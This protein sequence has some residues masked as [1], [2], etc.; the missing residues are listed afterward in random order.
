MAEAVNPLMQEFLFEANENL[1]SLNELLPHLEKN[2]ADKELLNKIYRCVHTVK[3]GA[4]F[5]KLIRLDELTH[6]LENLLDQV[7]DGKKSVDSNIIDVLLAG[8]DFM[9]KIIKAVESGAGEAK[10]DLGDILSKLAFVLN[11][12]SAPDVN[13]AP[14]KP[15]E[16]VHAQAKDKPPE[17]SKQEAAPFEPIQVSPL[18]MKSEPVASSVTAPQAK[19]PSSVSDSK[20]ANTS[21]STNDEKNIGD[22]VVRV[23]VNLLDKIM[24][25]VGELVLTRN[26][27]LQFANGL[28]SPDLYKLSNQLNSITTE[29]QGDIMRTR[30]QPIGSILS[31]FD[32]IVRDL[33]REMGKKVHLKV[34]GRDTELDKTLLEAIKDPL[35]HMVR[36]AVDHAIETCEQRVEAGKS[37]EG[38]LAIKAY[39]EGGQVTIEIKDDGRGIRKDKVLAKAIEKGIITKD[40]ASQMS[41]KE[42]FN[43]IFMPG[44]STAAQVTNISGRG[45][46]MDVV[47]TNIE[48]IGGQ[49]DLTSEEGL[50]TTFKLRI[51]LTLA[52]IPALVVHDKGEV[53][54]L[55]QIN[56]VELVRLEGDKLA[57]IEKINGAEFFRLRG[58]LIPLVRLSR[59][60]NL[61]SESH[62][63]G[64]AVEAEN[65]VVLNAEGRVYGL[66]VD[67]ILDTQEIVVKPL[68][69]QLKNLGYYAGATI[70][71]DGRVALILDVMGLAAKCELQSGDSAESEDTGSGAYASRDAQEVLLFKLNAKGTFCVP[72]VVVNRLEKI[73]SSRIEFIGEQ[74]TVRYREQP[75]PLIDLGQALGFA[76]IQDL[77]SREV[78]PVFVAVFGGKY[79][80]FIV[81]D[82]LDISKSDFDIKTNALEGEG[83]LGALF[84]NDRT[85]T[86]VDIY[87]VAEKLQ[88]N[89]NTKAVDLRNREHS[90]TILLAEDTA[91]FRKI[92][93]MTF[94]ALGYK[95]L[96]G[97]NGKE[98]LDLWKQHYSEIDLI[99]SDVE[100]PQMNG[101]EFA[102]EIRKHPQGARIPMIALT[103]KFSKE[104]IEAGKA[105]GFNMYLEKFK[106]QEIVEAVLTATKAG[107]AA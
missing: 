39:H 100:M 37:E 16:Q 13:V 45:V 69:K 49:I 8:I 43:I 106:K 44:F 31:R 56:L 105:A 38:I 29:I 72:L 85:V 95:V 65:I 25:V 41:E 32:R 35:T 62:Q 3:G 92:S 93:E 88:L 103:T 23:N 47:K 70:M 28:D 66:I 9:Q 83:T 6:N 99:V 5:V 20:V 74:M 46:G 78:V 7:R 36:N 2:P 73:D 40:R 67:A 17:Q 76:P 58:D 102:K 94:S 82:I 53:F 86:L 98:A 84:L 59:V 64:G 30:M 81:D 34:D 27:I 11:Q 57:L 89:S 90:K 24:N 12:S 48:K 87:Y 104:D 61:N 91:L 52:I 1:N 68:S 77:N 79:F 42:I 96:I 10:V 18:E 107:D 21:N 54:A 15:L 75:M 71:G 60:L 14:E 22:S 4:R 80:G 50:G 33:A 101:L 26:Q 51:P 19:S 97:H 55:P 63:A